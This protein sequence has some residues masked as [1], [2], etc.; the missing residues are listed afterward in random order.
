MDTKEDGLSGKEQKIG[1]YKVFIICIQG[2]LP[3][4]ACRTLQ[5]YPGHL[6]INMKRLKLENKQIHSH[7][8]PIPNRA[9]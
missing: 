7:K 5:C 1:D 6:S 8:L 9:A 4:P 3:Q 2:V